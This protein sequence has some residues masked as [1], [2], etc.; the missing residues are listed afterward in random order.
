[1]RPQ[2][3]RPNM[4]TKRLLIVQLFLALGLGCV[5]VLP[6]GSTQSPIGI[7]PVLP[8]TIGAWESKDVD[9]SQREKEGLA[10]DTQFA[11]KLYSDA[12]GNQIYVS[13]VLSG[14]DMVNSI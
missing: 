6:T 9:V 8:Q 10:K 4:I 13:I 7:E 3:R 2:K 12:L 5:F 14:Y 11:R 1:M